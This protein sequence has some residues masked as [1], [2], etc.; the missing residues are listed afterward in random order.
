MPGTRSFFF[1]CLGLALL[2]LIA[3]PVLSGVF[4]P[5]TLPDEAAEGFRVWQADDCAGCHTLDGQGGGDAP[6]LS[7]IYS[8]RGEVYLR[9]FLLN[10]AAL[11]AESARTVP[12]IALPEG[13]AEGALAFLK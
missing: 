13:E 12:H 7:H 1:A 9:Q 8:L 10:P 4:A 2:S 5:H 11:S 3:L 6:D